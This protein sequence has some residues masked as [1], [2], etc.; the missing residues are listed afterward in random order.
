MSK[1][2]GNLFEFFATLQFFE[3]VNREMTLRGIFHEI[4]IFFTLYCAFPLFVFLLVFTL[5][6]R[7]RDAKLR[8]GEIMRGFLRKLF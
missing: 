4:L 5:G 6:L 1:R 8:L 2:A 7:E 3:C